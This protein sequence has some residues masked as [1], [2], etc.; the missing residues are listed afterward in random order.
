MQRAARTA[1]FLARREHGSAFHRG[2]R[3]RDLVGPDE[4]ALCGNFEP[5]IWADNLVRMHVEEATQRIRQLSDGDLLAGL[6]G[7]LG[8]SRRLVALVLAHLSEVEERR[9]HLLAGYSSLFAY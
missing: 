7:A 8:A 5:E 1:T 3:P 4:T 6:N 9:L 2:P